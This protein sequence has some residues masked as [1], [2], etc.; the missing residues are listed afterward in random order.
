MSE[1]SNEEFF[2]NFDPGPLRDETIFSK[3]EIESFKLMVAN[4]EKFNAPTE[5][6]FITFVKSVCVDGDW[7]ALGFECPHCGHQRCWY[8]GALDVLYER[9]LT[10]PCHSCKQYSWPKF[11]K[12][13]ESWEL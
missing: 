2:M 13:D 5:Q 11:F 8:E 10:T 9:L 1:M 6:E 4:A 12:P 7:L 3:E